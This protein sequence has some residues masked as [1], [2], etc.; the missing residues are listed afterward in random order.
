MSAVFYHNAKFSVVPLSQ[1]WSGAFGDNSRKL[2][3]GCI[4]EEK[5]RGPWLDS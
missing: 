1:L 4:S 5:D 3:V 2:R